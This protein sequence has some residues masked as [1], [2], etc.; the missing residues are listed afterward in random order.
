MVWLRRNNLTVIHCISGT[1]F[2]MLFVAHCDMVEDRPHIEQLP[3][4]YAENALEPYISEETMTLH[5]HQ[6]YAGYVSSANRL[7]KRSDLKP[8]D[9]V[10]IIMETADDEKNVDI[11]NNVAQAWNHAFF[12]KCLN[13]KGGGKPE[14][15][16]AKF[17]DE[18]FGGFEGFKKEFLSAAKGQFGSGWVWLVQD[19]GELRVMA[20]ADAE[21]PFL[22][23]VTPIFVVD[24]WEHAYYLDYQNRRVEYVEAVLTHLADW[25]FAAS[26][27]REDG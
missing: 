5:F 1:L 19:G 6:H 22:F 17:I 20:T 4:P 26:Q 21:P 23:G 8:M 18:A 16:F 25:Q 3:L 14:G 2:L 13:P 15:A 10:E 27:L 24:L 11:F 7:L 9:E 12:W